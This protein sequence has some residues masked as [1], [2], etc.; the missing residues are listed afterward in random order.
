[1][2]TSLDER[3]GPLLGESVW[4]TVTVDPTLDE[5]SELHFHAV[6]D[7]LRRHGQHLP[8]VLQILEVAAYAHTTGYSLAQCLDARSTVLDISASTLKLGRETARQ[9]KL[10]L[11]QTR[12]VAADFHAL[13]FEDEQ[14]H[15]VFICSALHHTWNWK[16]VLAE[17]VRVLAPGGLLFLE[18]EPCLREFGFYL[19]RCNRMDNFTQFET[20]LEQLGIVRTIAEPYLGSRPETLF[21]MVENQTIPLCELKRSVESACDLLEFS[22]T[23]EICMGPLEHEMLKHRTLDVA[24][25]A[26]W[27]SSRLGRLVSQAA[28]F[29]G[30]VERGL[31]FSLPDDQMIATLSYRVAQRLKGLPA[32]PKPSFQ[33]QFVGILFVLARWRRK[34]I[35]YLERVGLPGFR[36]I[37]IRAMRVPAALQS[38]AAR[39]TT[40][41][42]CDPYR[43]GLARLFGAGVK[44][45][46]RKRGHMDAIV[47]GR[48]KKD[49]EEQERVVLGFEPDMLSLLGQCSAFSLDLQVSAEDAVRQVF[50]SDD[51]LIEMSLAGEVSCGILPKEWIVKSAERGIRSLVSR[52]DRGKI[53]FPLQTGRSLILL[54]CHGAYFGQPYRIKLVQGGR[55]LDLMEV[56]QSESFLL[57][58]IAETEDSP[59][60]GVSLQMVALDGGEEPFHARVSLTYAV[61]IKL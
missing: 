22:V 21:G 26:T 25:L 49:Y 24:K 17:I 50:P 14:F 51:W 9:Q 4:H 37:L 18:N 59:S 61:A 16:L 44:I 42:Q 60:D 7:I 55:E 47:E 8:S 33:Q 19:F 12:L 39:A 27:L 30:K 52:S 56:Y 53:L 2:N 48:L 45:V 29:L 58:G 23:P 5:V 35:R 41:F 46:A 3:F 40:S 11:D 38:Q 6:Q 15:V 28:P 36:Q 57:A 54:R 43:E 10:S 1:M 32:P 13:P 20:K 34:L 31:G